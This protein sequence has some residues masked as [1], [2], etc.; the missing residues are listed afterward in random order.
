MSAPSGRATLWLPR[1]LLWFSP[2]R[3]CPAIAFTPAPALATESRQ[4]WRL[5]CTRRCRDTS[6]IRI[7]SQFLKPSNL[8][9]D[10][11]KVYY[12][13][14]IPNLFIDYFRIYYHRKI[15]NLFRDNCRSRRFK[16]KCSYAF[17]RLNR[18]GHASLTFY[19]DL[20]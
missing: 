1:S 4:C 11:F 7:I 14:K 3:Y 16:W 8:F 19:I 9:I 17:L 6:L 15:P 10:Y 2:A 12:H 18:G 5:L 20:L 13:R